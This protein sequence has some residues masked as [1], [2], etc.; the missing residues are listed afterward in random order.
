MLSKFTAQWH[1]HL[2]I[3]KT[4]HNLLN[5]KSRFLFL[6]IPLKIL[7]VGAIS[8]LQFLKW[9]VGRL[10]FYQK[11]VFLRFF[12]KLIKLLITFKLPPSLVNRCRQKVLCSLN[13]CLQL[14]LDSSPSLF[15][16]IALYF[17]MFS[18]LHLKITC[19]CWGRLHMAEIAMSFISQWII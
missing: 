8:N 2:Q 11:K 7:S 3:Y 12:C 17:L 13:F 14:W 10:N 16:I 6:L 1:Y 9:E 18:F 5:I 15:S 4:A 19:I